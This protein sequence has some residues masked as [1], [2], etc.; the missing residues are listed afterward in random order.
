MY[1]RTSWNCK[2]RSQALWHNNKHQSPNFIFLLVIFHNDY[3]SIQMIVMVTYRPRAMKWVPIL[4]TKR[5]FKIFFKTVCIA[6]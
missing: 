1:V 2:R 4:D 5:H 3:L 6:A